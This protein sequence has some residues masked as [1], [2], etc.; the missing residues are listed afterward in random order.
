MS[1]LLGGSVSQD[2]DPHPYGSPGDSMMDAM[3]DWDAEQQQAPK[4]PPQRRSTG[5]VVAFT[6]V[7]CLLLGL[8]GIL[9]LTA[10][11]QRLLRPSC[12]TG[13]RRPRWRTP[14]PTP[15]RG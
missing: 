14:T 3:W 1:A 9:G 13:A 11:A 6:L 7:G 10:V 8:V 4:P 5:S 2:A 15:P 12:S